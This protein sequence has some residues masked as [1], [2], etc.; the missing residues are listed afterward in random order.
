[1]LT[2]EDRFV[3]KDLFRK[4]VSISEIARRTG[5]D[6]KTI[7]QVVTTPLLVSPADRPPWKRRAHKLDPYVPYLEHR[8]AEGVRT[9]HKLFTEIEAHG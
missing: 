6:R 9:A 8:I 1:M 2:V 3:I 7:R 5:H 4:G